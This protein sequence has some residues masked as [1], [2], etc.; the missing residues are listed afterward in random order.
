MKILISSNFKR[1]FSTYIDFLDHYWLNFFDKKKYEFLLVPN[2]TKLATK[3][4][5]N[6]KIIDL[7][8]IPGG[9]DLFEKSKISKSRLKVE[10]LLIKL[11]I[12]K[13]IPLLGVCRGM[14]HINHYFGGSLSKIKG[15]MRKSHN[16]YL[17][18]NLFLKDRMIVN[19][20]HN[21]GVKKINVAKKF[22]IL[23][24]DSNNNIEMFEHEQKK[25][26]GVMWHPEREKNYKKLELI[27]KRLVKKK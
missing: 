21:F 16:I 9:N 12:I 23:A 1:H 14:Q 10:N 13:K 11:S 22:K 17:K 3:L 5:K 19:S 20:Y 26:I 27:F 7:I 8:I 24:V 18:D 4:I 6:N 2:S 15:H 25:I